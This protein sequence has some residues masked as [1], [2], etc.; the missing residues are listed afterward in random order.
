MHFGFREVIVEG[1]AEIHEVIFLVLLLLVKN[2][3]YLACVDLLDL[4][5]QVLGWLGWPFGNG[6][7]IDPL[8]GVLLHQVAGT[9]ILAVL[10][11]EQRRFVILEA[12]GLC[13]NK[14][15]RR[16]LLLAEQ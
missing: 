12:G 1:V 6:V 4:F 9:E 11:Y 5:D 8:E 2:L 3:L 13:G 15:P 16:F 10:L 14:V 7:I